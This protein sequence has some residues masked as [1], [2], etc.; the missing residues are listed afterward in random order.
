MHGKIV[1]VDWQDEEAALKRLYL[2]E[3]EATVK[4]RLHL[5]WL[6]RSGK[7]V[8]DATAVVGCHLRTA[9]QWLAWYRE[10]GVDA[11]R[12]KKGGNAR[13]SSSRLSPA[14]KETLLAQANKDGFESGLAVRDYI[15]QT[16]GIV[17]TVGGVY[18][19]LKRL[20]IKKKVPR[21]MNVKADPAVQEAYKKGG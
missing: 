13:G 10:G 7:Q 17:Y 3:K 14:Q 21:P 6:V 4:A 19:L 5:L 12:S 18:G 1:Q 2:T 8:K 9:Q 15:E 20:R 11:V 16:F